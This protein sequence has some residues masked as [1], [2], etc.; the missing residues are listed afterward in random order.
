MYHHHLH[1]NWQ[2]ANNSIMLIRIAAMFGSNL[3]AWCSPCDHHGL[4]RF[5]PAESM[6]HALAP[7]VGRMD[8]WAGRKRRWRLRQ[9]GLDRVGG[10]HAGKTWDTSFLARTC[11][12]RATCEREEEVFARATCGSATCAGGLRAG[13]LRNPPSTSSGSKCD[14]SEYTGADQRLDLRWP[15]RRRGRPRLCLRTDQ[16]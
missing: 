9:E 13:G 12:A 15:T 8:R 4:D 10:Q 16:T 5:L 14:P 11:A 6:A 1:R 7:G 3:R 2:P